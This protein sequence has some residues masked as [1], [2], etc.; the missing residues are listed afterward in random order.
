MIQKI[1]QLTD[2]CQL[3]LFNQFELN[4]LNNQSK[5][6]LIEHLIETYCQKNNIMAFT[7]T[8]HLLLLKY[9]II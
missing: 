4:E 6:E 5:F 8:Y 7:P 2:L 9:N 1:N 3:P